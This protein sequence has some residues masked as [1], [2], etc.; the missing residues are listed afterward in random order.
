ME[1]VL[2]ESMYRLP[3]DRDSVEK[4]I[5]TPASVAGTEEPGRVRRSRRRKAAQAV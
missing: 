2:L 4:L 5:V 1:R 3:S